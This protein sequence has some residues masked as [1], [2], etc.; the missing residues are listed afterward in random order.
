MFFKKKPRPAAPILHAYDDDFDELLGEE[1]GVTLV[2]FWAE[3]CGPCKMMELILDEIS[4]E[5]A[6]RGVRVIKVEVDQAPETMARFGVKSIPTLVFFRD[7]EPQFEMV[8]MIPKPVL[9]RE[10]G[11]LLGAA[12]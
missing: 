7:G 10:I 11:E 8:G 1:N 2:D 6:D 12:E 4:I 5:Q 9:E 3:W